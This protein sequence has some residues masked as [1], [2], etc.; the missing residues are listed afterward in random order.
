M[1]PRVLS[2]VAE[3]MAPPDC[4][5]EGLGVEPE[6]VEPEGAEPEGVDKEELPPVATFDVPLICLASAANAAD[7]RGE[8]SSELMAS[9]IPVV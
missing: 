7:E 4:E 1:N 8:D 2:P 3:R 9:T 6:G 5:A